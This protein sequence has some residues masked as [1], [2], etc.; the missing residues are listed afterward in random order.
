MRKQFNTIFGSLALVVL[1]LICWGC[2]EDAKS[3]EEG[4]V[5]E[6]VNDPEEPLFQNGVRSH[7]LSADV[8]LHFRSKGNTAALGEF[9]NYYVNYR[10]KEVFVC[11]AEGFGHD[12]ES[13]VKLLRNKEDPDAWLLLFSRNGGY[14]IVH[15]L[16]ISVDR[17]NEDK[18]SISELPFTWHGLSLHETEN[19]SWLLK[20]FSSRIL[21]VDRVGKHPIIRLAPDVFAVFGKVS[22]SEKGGVHL[23]TGD[24][25]K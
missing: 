7:E 18:V 9:G 8:F 5:S 23:T 21:R 22:H 25:F 13:D 11:E 3:P 6:G 17:E 14:A 19:E 2:S 12:P 24:S 1:S 20:A 10:G 4:D 16:M 15:G